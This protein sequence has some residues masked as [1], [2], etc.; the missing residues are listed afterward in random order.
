MLFQSTFTECASSVQ[1]K[2]ETLLRICTALQSGQAVLQVLGLV[3]AFGNIMNGGNR[4]RGQADGFTLD[5]L[6]K[7]KDVKSSKE[8]CVYPLPEPQDLFQ[9]SQMKFEDFERELRKLR[10][11]LNACSSETEKV[12]NVSSEEHMQPFKEK[13]EEFLSKA[14]TEL[15]L[16]DKRLTETQMMFQKLSVFY[17]V[18]PKAGEKEVSPNT[19]FSVWHEFSS[20]FKEQWK[21]E[22]KILL[23]ERLKAAEETFRQV[24]EKASYSV[25]PKHA[26][27]MKAKLGQKM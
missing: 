4:S 21:R 6:P 20:D 22:N 25:K 2:L 1:R 24:R 3:L 14:K 7:L 19:F 9:A 18:K 10:K 8:T 26:S 17:S 13:M 12:C 5:I 15:G 23:K 16:Q 11:D 27:G